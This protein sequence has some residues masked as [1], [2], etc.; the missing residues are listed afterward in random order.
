MK[1]SKS[2]EIDNFQHIFI[3]SG[4][5]VWCLSII[6]CMCESLKLN[7]CLCA[8][9]SGYDR[10]HINNESECISIIYNSKVCLYLVQYVTY[11]LLLVHVAYIVLFVMHGFHVFKFLATISFFK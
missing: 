6:K 1:V 7:I 2:A 11:L 8:I 4:S 10:P 3:S 5:T 9:W